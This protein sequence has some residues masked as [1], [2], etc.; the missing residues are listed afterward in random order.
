MGFYFG[1]RDTASEE[2]R[3]IAGVLLAGWHIEDCQS[4]GVHEYRHRYCLYNSQGDLRG[5]FATKFT[6]ALAADTWMADA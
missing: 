5:F 2:E 4:R 6:A 1:G 3:V